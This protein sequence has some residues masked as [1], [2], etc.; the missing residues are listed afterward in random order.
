MKESIPK[1]VND[2]IRAVFYFKR[3]GMRIYSY[4]HPTYVFTQLWG[5]RSLGSIV[6]EWSGVRARV[7]LVL[8]EYIWNAPAVSFFLSAFDDTGFL[9]SPPR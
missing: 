4:I 8:P 1:K 7:I 2:K 9:G 6:A 5:G 3:R